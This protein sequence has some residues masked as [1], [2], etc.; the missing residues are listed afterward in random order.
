MPAVPQPF[1]SPGTPG[2][3]PQPMPATAPLVMGIVNVTPDSFS[4]GGRHAD[5][6]G[7][8][9]HAIRLMDEGAQVVDVG[10]ESTRPGAQPVDT[11][12]E[13]ARVVPVVE[14]LAAVAT[15]RKVRLSV[16][17]R[18]PEVAA[19]AVAA[20]ATLLNDVSASL[21]SLAADLGVGWIAMHMQGSPGTMQQRPQYGDVVGEVHD[22][23]VERATRA[24]EL[25]CP[26]VWVDP[27]LG[28]G[29]TAAHNLMLLAAVDRL[30]AAG[31]PV[32]VGS[33][34]KRTLA[35]VLD[36]SDRR[37]V[38]SGDPTEADSGFEVR[39]PP[40]DRLEGSLATAVWAAWHGAAM[41]RVH[42]V[43]AT[44]RALALFDRTL[45]GLDPTPAR[46]GGH[47]GSESPSVRYD[48]AK[49]AI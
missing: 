4:D 16:D 24:R 5:V 42:D 28:F 39:V 30:V 3:A 37:A 2:R 48:T 47:V 29:K 10:G 49:E 8:V 33:S 35:L 32:L 46:V 22:F 1:S 25:G 34:R 15:E 40:A 23:L 44:V 36:R 18:T 38:L 26:E 6:D 31:F 45:S 41:L 9:A 11:H 13:L 12:T 17:T 14:R 7:A 19:A 20:G 43:A 21:G 27:G